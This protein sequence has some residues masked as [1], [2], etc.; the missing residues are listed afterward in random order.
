MRFLVAVV[1]FA[2][3]FL[4]GCVDN[5]DNLP[6]AYSKDE[7]EYLPYA[8]DQ[9]LVFQD[10]VGDMDTMRVSYLTKY[11]VVEDV[12]DCTI[13][14]EYIECKI[15][16]AEPDSNT[17]PIDI[18]FNVKETALIQVGNDMQLDNYIPSINAGY[19]YGA[20]ISVLGKTFE[21]FLD[22]KCVDNTCGPV[23][24]VIFAKGKGLV[25][26][27]NQHGWKVLVE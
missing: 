18:V 12:A 6:Q 1:L 2:A 20:S 4:S 15:T 11:P 23:L 22:L 26:L 8:Y 13:S 5:C 3:F 16:T 19:S 25:A 21:A 24:E 14:T 17:A 7:A 27:R 9:K 10:S